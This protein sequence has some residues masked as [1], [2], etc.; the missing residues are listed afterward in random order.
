MAIDVKYGR[1]TSPD[2]GRA[3]AEIMEQ[4][5]RE[6]PDGVIVFCSPDYELEA[7]G[8]ELRR[9]FPCPVV[10]CTSSGQIGPDG[11]EHSG[12]LGISFHGGG[13]RLRPF[14]ISPL[15][16]YAEQTANIAEEI[17][18]H[19][20]TH[21]ARH[22]F[23]LL[24]VDG[25]SMLEERLVA[26]LY[27]G[28][29]NIPIIGGSAGDN[30]RFERTHVYD[31]DGRFLSGAAVFAL[32]ESEA[33]ITT[34]KVQHFYPSDIELVITAADPELRI[35]HEMNGEPAAVAYADAL[36]IGVE[37][38]NPA[39]FSRHPLVLTFGKAPYVRSI[40]KAN[41]DLSLS[42][43]C[44]IEEGLIVTVG[45]AIDPLHTLETAFSELHQTLPDISVIIG[46]DCILRRLEFEQE[47]ID[48]QIGSLMAAHRVFG[49][50]TYGEQFNGVHVNQT[51]TAVAIGV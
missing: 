14:I 9:A 42:C 25:L 50:S 35:I 45:T 36:G 1:S 15:T 32:V 2:P 38:L 28:I 47:G 3:V 41:D 17:R 49:F 22:R 39:I 18:Q 46:F 5:G 8:Q 7:L 21:P 16:G 20:A 11:F 34:F 10:G 31:G 37:D 13:I 12:I 30:L 29:G 40:Q 48:G 51:F 33:P 44:A 43:Y 19:C 4:F 24:L 26:S 6:H 23:G 27:Q